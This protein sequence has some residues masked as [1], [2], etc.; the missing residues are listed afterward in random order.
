M[1]WTGLERSLF[2]DETLAL[3]EHALQHGDFPTAAGHI[4]AASA[5]APAD[6]LVLH[7]AGRMWELCD[8]PQLALRHWVHAVAIDPDTALSW[9]AIGTMLARGEPIKR[10]QLVALLAFAQAQ[11]AQPEWLLPAWHLALMYH[12]LGFSDAAH[13]ALVRLFGLVRQYGGH[14]KNM[15]TVNMHNRAYMHLAVGQWAEGFACYEYRLDDVAHVLNKRAVSRVPADVPRYIGGP[16]PK[17]VAVFVEQGAG[18]MLMVLPYVVELTRH[19]VRVALEAF[20]AMIE[21]L[22]TRMTPDTWS[23]V[24]L[25]EQDAPIPVPVDA[26]VWAMSLPGLFGVPTD[27]QPTM[28]RSWRRPEHVNQVAFCWQG[29][30]AHKSDQIRSMPVDALRVVADAVRRVGLVPVACNPGE[31]TPDFLEAPARPLDTF[32]DTAR[33]LDSCV[34][35]VSVDTALV[36]LAGSMGVPTWACLAALPDWRWG[37]T[38]RANVWYPSVQLMRQPIIGDWSSVA[39]AVATELADQFGATAP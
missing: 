30:R 29:S 32:S 13:A 34:A 31:P 15:G 35:V 24:D 22:A 20:P 18:D 5:M 27:P 1:N 14:P 7:A 28:Q 19:G 17:S 12:A 23:L 10:P 4:N 2:V 25:F 3:T 21:L 39:S 11:R 38:G 33:V 9:A 16:L 37:L 36:H 8:N 6:P 26:Y